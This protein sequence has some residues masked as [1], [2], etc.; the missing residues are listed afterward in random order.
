MI[1]LTDNKDNFSK[2]SLNSA[3]RTSSRCLFDSQKKNSLPILQRILSGSNFKNKNECIKNEK[4]EKSTNNI[5]RNKKT[6]SLGNTPNLNPLALL[7]AKGIMPNSLYMKNSVVNK[8][9]NKEI[10]TNF[11]KKVPMLL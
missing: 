6:N 4:D 8:N 9:T 10:I 1:N 3:Y 5:R 2:L 11:E 7:E